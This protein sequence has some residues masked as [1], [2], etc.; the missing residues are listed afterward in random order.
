[1]RPGNDH[2]GLNGPNQKDGA[3]C[4]RGPSI[5]E[6]TSGGTRGKQIRKQKENSGPVYRG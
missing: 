3:G 1:V 5:G 4:T 2:T 6:N